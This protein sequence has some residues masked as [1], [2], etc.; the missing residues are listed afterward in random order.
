MR[1][2]LLSFVLSLVLSSPAFAQ[3]DT[4]RESSQG[5]LWWTTI[6]EAVM[7]SKIADAA[8]FRVGAPFEPGESGGGGAFSFDVIGGNFSGMH[9]GKRIEVVLF[10]GG[11]NSD[12]GGE[13][14]LFITAPGTWGN[15]SD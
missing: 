10:T 5:K 9:S 3:S 12:G 1:R 6:N 2:G 8:K 11:M 4:I 14:G 7:D 13:A 15:I